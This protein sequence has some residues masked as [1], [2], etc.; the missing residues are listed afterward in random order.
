MDAD[1]EAPVCES[2]EIVIAARPEIVWDALTDLSSWPQ[3]MPGVEKVDV[4]EPVEV[5][6]TFRWKA[7][8]STIRSEIVESDRPRSVAWKGHTFGI[9]AVHV[10]RMAVEDGT[11]RVFTEESWSGFV[12][13]VLR[14]MM[15]KTVRKTLDG[16]LPA[17]KEEAERRSRSA[18][19]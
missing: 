5:G 17:L 8:P 16:G 3:W 13:R 19:I 2:G 11:T 1:R 14:G 10:W 12:P 18:S 6:T 4:D 15:K 7:G 9:T